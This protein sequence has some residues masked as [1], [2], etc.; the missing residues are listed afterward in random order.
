MPGV[1]VIVTGRDLYPGERFKDRKMKADSNVMD[2]RDAGD[3][4]PEWK[5]RKNTRI[6]VIGGMGEMGSLFTRFFR[7]KGFP[8]AVSDEKAGLDNL[9]L[10]ETS[11]IVVVAVPLHL[12]VDVIRS[13]VPHFRSDQLLV[14]L[15]SLKEIPLREMLRSRAS[16]V[17]LHPMFGGR[18]SSFRGQTLVA[19]PARVDPVEWAHFRDVFTQEGIRVKETTA[20]EHDRMMSIIQ[21][22][23]HLTTMLTGRVLRE[24]GVDIAE[25]LEYT[26]PSYRLEVNTIGRMF[27]Q[28]GALYSAITQ[29][30][31]CTGEIL[32]HLMDGLQCY[33]KWYRDGDLN[34]FVE[35]FQLSAKHL[36]DF[37]R[38]A[39]RESS[40]ILDFTVKLTNRSNRS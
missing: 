16:V 39:Y 25:T 30:N 34:S 3:A 21:V 11:D 26:S 12:T 15:S 36:G 9:G 19:C 33:E 24:L 14:D 40:A 38:D 1:L 6:G 17:G 23:F 13:I 2:S 35:D 8:V 20:A 22:L 28:N 29:L 37:C 7:E 32:Q 5:W 4:L 10:V 27:A 18:I 31:P